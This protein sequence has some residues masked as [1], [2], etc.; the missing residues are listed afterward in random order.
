MP[1]R[2]EIADRIIAMKLEHQEAWM[3]PIDARVDGLRPV[4]RSSPPPW[5][6]Q[7][8]VG[9]GAMKRL[10]NDHRCHDV[11][12]FAA[13]GSR[14]IMDVPLRPDP[15]LEDEGWVI[16]TKKGGRNA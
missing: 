14:R 10:L 1:L 16:D 8:R 3:P 13:D 5:P 4:A 2:H 12:S 15:S 7:V 9:F 11:I 6:V